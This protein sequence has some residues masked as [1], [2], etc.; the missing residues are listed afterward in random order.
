MLSRIHSRRRRA[1][2]ALFALAL[3]SG[4]GACGGDDDDDTATTDD[5]GECTTK[6]S[7]DCKPT[8]DPPTYDKIFENVLRPTCGSSASGTQCHGKQG[9]QAGLVLADHDEAYQSL[10]GDLDGRA[11]VVPG[12][13][14]CSILIARLESTEKRFRMPLNS[15]PL[16]DGLRCAI[17]QWIANG[18]EK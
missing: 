15:D 2:C 1:L 4:L 13:P 17:E 14:E 8:F 10:L 3:C 6:V 7:L 18:A 12:K 16:D 9:M 11:R 5:G